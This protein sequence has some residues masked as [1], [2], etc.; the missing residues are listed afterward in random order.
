MAR[1]AVLR[2]HLKVHR[3]HPTVV[4]RRHLARWVVR[5]AHRNLVRGDSAQR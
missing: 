5:S 3:L 1:A 4:T 2:V